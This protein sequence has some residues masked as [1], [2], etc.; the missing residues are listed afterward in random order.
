MDPSAIWDTADAVTVRFATPDDARD[1]VRLAQLDS[2]RVPAGPTLV[3]EVDG[4]LVAALVLGRGIVV[5]DPFRHT[6]A[7]VRL[8][9]LREQQLRGADRGRRPA[10]RGLGQRRAAAAES[11]P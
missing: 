7:L 3:A 10:L 4:Q 1:L 8:L 5:A 2:G 9:E 11:R 6:A